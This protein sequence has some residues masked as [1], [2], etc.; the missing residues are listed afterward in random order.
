M[1]TGFLEIVWVFVEN[2]LCSFSFANTRISTRRRMFCSMPSHSIGQLSSVAERLLCKQ[3]VVGSI[4]TVG[5]LFFDDFFA[6]IGKD[7]GRGK[8][9]K[10]GRQ[11]L[12]GSQ[13]YVNVCR[14]TQTHM[15]KAH[16]DTHAECVNNGQRKRCRQR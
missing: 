1:H 10:K 11:I 16:T 3:S 6:I 5:Y 15:Q 14:Y 8:S 4:P 2:D 13:G 9:D 12:L 7:R